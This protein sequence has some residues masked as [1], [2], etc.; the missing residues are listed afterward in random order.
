MP[1]AH[2]VAQVTLGD[3]VQFL[4]HRPHPVHHL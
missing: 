3:A 2:D 1:D 4:I